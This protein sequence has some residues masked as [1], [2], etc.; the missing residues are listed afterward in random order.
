MSD[1]TY[2]YSLSFDEKPEY[3]H[4]IVHGR[5]TYDN[6]TGY[7]Q[8]ILRECQARHCRAVLIEERLEG[9]R[10]D[11]L[12]VFEIASRHGKPLTAP[13]GPIAYVDVN[14]H[15]D[16]MDFAE[17]VAVNRAIPVKVFETV[18]GAQEWLLARHR[19]AN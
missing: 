18:A 8:E 11:I 6:V 19:A 16:L 15:G 14:R 10:L 9:P 3:L 7:L 13:I 5:N 1:T 2:T 17:N 12:D 4:C